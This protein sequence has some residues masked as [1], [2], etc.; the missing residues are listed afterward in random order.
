MLWVVFD[1]V[2][3]Y[4]LVFFCVDDGFVDV[5]YFVGCGGFVLGVVVV[6]LFFG[7]DLDVI[8]V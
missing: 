1:Y 4:V 2:V 8:G 7:E 6:D 5:D 3:W